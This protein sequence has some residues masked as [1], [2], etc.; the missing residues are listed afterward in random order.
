MKQIAVDIREAVS[1]SKAGKGIFNL[2]ITKELIKNKSFKWILLTDQTQS[3]F[4][5]SPNVEIVNLNTKGLRWHFKAK[6][7]LKKNKVDHYLAQTS[8]LTPLLL[9]STPY[10]IVVHDLISFLYP[11][12]HARFPKLIEKFCLPKIIK[13]A[14][15]IFT[16][17]NS[18]KNDLI[19][20]FPKITKSK[21]SITY[22]GSEH[23]ESK[24]NSKKQKIILTSGTIIPRKN[25]LNLIKAFEIIADQIDHDL[26]IAGNPGPNSAQTIDYIN[27]S[28]Q[29]N[30]IKLLGYVK[31]NDL[32]TL[33]SK[34]EIFVYPSFYEGFGIP[35]LE[36]LKS[37]ALVATSNTSSLP[38]VAGDAALLFEPNNPKDIADKILELIKNKRTQEKLIKNSKTQIEK[39]SWK[40]SAQSILE[41]LK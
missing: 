15:N 39:F 41:K 5:S 8:Y 20:L 40:T 37:N 36:A 14:K 13:K 23:I 24:P 3:E 18:T 4:K 9:S 29:K 33:Y 35:I 11:E 6:S 27:N 21:I 2:H 32:E 10:S 22:C 12:G 31:Q 28:P 26:L 25:H 34:S 17:S 19:K 1:T 7:Y 38:E 16:V 30:R